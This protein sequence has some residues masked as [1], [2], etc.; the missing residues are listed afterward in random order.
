MV[1]SGVR[2]DVSQVLRVSWYRFRVT[3]SRRWSEW[4]AI[5]L[6]AGLVGGLSMASISAARRIQS[7]YPTFLR[8][9]N[10][11]D[12]TVS[13]GSINSNG[14]TGSASFTNSID[15]LA[16][17]KRVRDLV[18]PAI[19]PLNRKGA[20]RL[21]LTGVIQLYGSLD[22]ELQDQDR[23]TVVKGEL[24]NPKQADEVV[25]TATAAHDLGLHVGQSVPL[26]FYTNSQTEHA[27]FGS[28][29]VKPRLRVKA[30]LTG[31]VVLNNQVVEDDVDRANAF[32]IVTPALIRDVA[33][34]EPSATAPIIYDLQLEHG[35][36]DI[37]KVEREFIRVVP[38]HSGYEIH[39]TS[40]AT[41][42]VELS[43]KPESV[44]LGAFG[45]IAALVALV[46]AMQA[47]SRQLRAGEVDRRIIRALGASPATTTGDGLIGVLAAILAGSLLA[48]GLAVALSPLA[49]LG[50]VRAVYPDPGVN[51]DWTVLG[52]G[53]L[54]L[55]AGLGIAGVAL[56]RRGAPHRGSQ[57]GRRASRGSAF[58]RGAEA[59]GLP[60]SGVMGVRFAFSPG[61]GPNAVPVRS[62][63]TGTV[64]AV[65]LLVGTL[66]FAS[67]LSTLVS[68]PPLYGW[69]W[70]YMLNP[71]TTSHRKR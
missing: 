29:S 60:I 20:P 58:T 62:A 12:L 22:G 14:S 42:Q 53:F 7:S 56:S 57:Q 16:G 27:G 26:G 44:A 68:H 51:V 11:S 46:L 43:V 48:V 18:A 54:V 41:A 1:L 49:P 21:A 70:S 28:P 23:V 67:S 13:A 69:N 64:L 15:H 5:V 9:T 40:R 71:A 3:W 65:T 36:R 61:S 52:T 8:S 4:L 47:I 24:F 34:I 10:P 55:V 63:L 25:M 2:V 6:L 19:I 50:A 45:A 33:A 39:V 31:I 32:V 59:A 35:S 38:P 37:P 66:T 30:T 17:V